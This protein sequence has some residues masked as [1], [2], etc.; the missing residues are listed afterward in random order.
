MEVI[1]IAT[2]AASVTWL[3]FYIKLVIDNDKV[4]ML[5]LPQLSFSDSISSNVNNSDQTQKLEFHI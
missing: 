5:D 4:I 2:I 1:L 3:L